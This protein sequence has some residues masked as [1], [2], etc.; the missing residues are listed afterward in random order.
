MEHQKDFH[1]DFHRDY[2]RPDVKVFDDEVL[3][4]LQF[5]EVAVCHCSGAGSRVCYGA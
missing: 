2:Q 5:D 3:I 1:R 4:E